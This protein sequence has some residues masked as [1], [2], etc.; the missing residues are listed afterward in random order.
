MVRQLLSRSRC[1]ARDADAGRRRAGRRRERARHDTLADATGR[2]GG[3]GDHL[4]D[5][6]GPRRTVHDADRVAPHQGVVARPRRHGELSAGGQR[7]SLRGVPEAE[8][9]LRHRALG[10]RRGRWIDGLGTQGR[11][12]HV[13]HRWDC[14]G[15][16]KRLLRE[17]R[18]PAAGAGSERRTPGVV[19]EDAGSVCVHVAAD[20]STWC[21]LPRRRRIGRHLVRRLGGHRRGALVGRR[22]ERG[23][24]LTG[25]HRRR[26]LRLLRMRGV[27]PLRSVDRAAHVDAIHRVFRGRRQD[28]G[29]PRRQGVRA[30]LPISGCA[31]RGDGRSRRLVHLFDHAG[32]RRQDRVLPPG[33]YIARGRHRDRPG[34]LEP[35]GGRSPRH[36]P[37]R[38]RVRGGHRVIDRRH[39]RARRP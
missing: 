23:P 32:V 4:S 22:P 15:R 27:L 31:R 36:R 14:G 20:G 25:S 19:R 7:P 38:A 18:R 16:R 1:A 11:R 8:R 35:S 17:L 34:A 24:Q 39:L 26:G 10:A 6:H 13:L 28:P 5:D 37:D 9:R 29:R 30:R 21:R 2:S 33:R 3:I 12:R